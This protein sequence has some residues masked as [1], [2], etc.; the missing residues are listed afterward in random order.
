MEEKSTVELSL[1]QLFLQSRVD[2]FHHEVQDYQKPSTVL[3][4]WL[5]GCFT[6]QFRYYFVRLWLSVTIQFKALLYDSE[7][8]CSANTTFN[9]PKV[10]GSN[11]K[12]IL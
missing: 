7:T 3:S 5:N 9:P 10:E 2:I 11:L 12:L 1:A 4:G 6:F 8:N